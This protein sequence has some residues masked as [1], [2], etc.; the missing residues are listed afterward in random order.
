MLDPQSPLVPAP[1]AAHDWLWLIPALPLAAS[2]LCGVLHYIEARKRLP[3]PAAG[4]H[5]HH[6]AH[7]HAA[8]AHDEHQGDAHH[9]DGHGDHGHA[10][11][12]AGVAALAPVLAIASRGAAVARSREGV[13]LRRAAGAPGALRAANG[14]G[15]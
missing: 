13:F 7:A 4:G 9:D 1:D 10:K 11:T 8:H 14:A 5:G 15:S 2:A 3:K 6:A 12:P